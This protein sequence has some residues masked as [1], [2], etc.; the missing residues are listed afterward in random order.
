MDA[1][2]T[3]AAVPGRP[4]PK[5]ITAAAVAAMR[6]GSVVVD[7]AAESGG[8]C[9]VTR[10]GEE[11]VH[12]GVTVVGLTNLASSM[13]VHASQLYARNVTTLL[14]HLLA[15]GELKLDFQD[16]IT[17]GACVARPTVAA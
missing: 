6:R 9:E 14:E 16:E 5:L 4:A 17:A 8:N 11:I 3:T 2:V 12:E 7:V 13:P 10:P 1:V 15:D